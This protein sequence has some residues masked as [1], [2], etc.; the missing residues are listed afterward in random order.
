[1]SSQCGYIGVMAPVACG[2]PKV[3]PYDADIRAVLKARVRKIHGD[4]PSTA[5]IDEL[6]LRR[7]RARA[8]VAVINGSMHGYENQV[9]AR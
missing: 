8:D 6:A 4:D 7:R 5:V 9:R 2:V 3:A 1:M